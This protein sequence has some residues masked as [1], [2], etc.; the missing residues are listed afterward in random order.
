MLYF[1][2][3]NAFEQKVEERRDSLFQLQFLLFSWQTTFRI[4][5]YTLYVILDLMMCR[6]SRKKKAKIAMNE[7]NDVIYTF[8]EM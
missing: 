2:N 4:L 3:N 7:F 1:L 8:L 6:G 5:N